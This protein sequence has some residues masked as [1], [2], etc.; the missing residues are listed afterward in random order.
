MPLAI[1]IR[2]ICP[3]SRTNSFGSPLLIWNSNRAR[4]FPRYVT[5]RSRHSAGRIS[6]FRVE[7][8]FEGGRTD[9]STKTSLILIANLFFPAG[10]SLSLPSRYVLVPMSS[11]LWAISPSSPKS[12]LNDSTWG[13]IAALRAGYAVWSFGGFRKRFSLRIVSNSCVQ[14][15]LVGEAEGGG[16]MLEP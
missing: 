6:R 9:F 13:A 3:S 5:C 12:A 15:V 10:P 8:L 1:N 11:R 4:I 7:N 14:L 2:G 16:G